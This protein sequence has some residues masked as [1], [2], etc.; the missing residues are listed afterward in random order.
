MFGI[1]STLKFKTQQCDRHSV[2][3]FSPTIFQEKPQNPVAQLLTAEEPTVSRGMAWYFKPTSVSKRSRIWTTWRQRRNSTDENIESEAWNSAALDWIEVSVEWKW[4]TTMTIVYYN[5][6]F[7]FRFYCN[8]IDIILIR[9]IL[10]YII[11]LLP[12]LRKKLMQADGTSL[13][14]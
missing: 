2:P 8:C 12:H 9:I 5:I 13:W 6:I 3:F 4:V 1:F 7:I 11:R 14:I 10:S